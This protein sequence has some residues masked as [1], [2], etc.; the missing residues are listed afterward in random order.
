MMALLSPNNYER[1]YSN[2]DQF[3][4]YVSQTLTYWFGD[5]LVAGWILFGFHCWIILTVYWL[6]F[7]QKNGTLQRIGLF[8]WISIMIQHLY[9]NGCWLVKC[10]RRLWETR[11]WFGPWTI[12]FRSVNNAGLRL[13]SYT[14]NIVFYIYA[15]AVTYAAVR[16]M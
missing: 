16:R 8:L 5:R 13:K 9:F 3:I 2:Q 4:E 15:I 14:M 7:A 1:Q 12:V 10:E 6:L 11:D